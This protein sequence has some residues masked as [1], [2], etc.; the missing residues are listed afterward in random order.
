MVVCFVST[1]PQKYMGI[2]TQM[3]ERARSYNL[4]PYRVVILEIITHTMV[5]HSSIGTITCPSAP[6]IQQ[7]QQV[8]STRFVFAA[9]VRN[10]RDDPC[11]PLTHNGLFKKQEV[12][13]VT[14]ASLFPSYSAEHK[15][16][17]G[18]TKDHRSS[19]QEKPLRYLALVACVSK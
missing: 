12:A 14:E 2:C 13:I 4:H 19:R 11:A 5:C 9:Y 7:A 8:N 6:C 16:H 10:K 18:S 17:R 15:S 3:V 1:S